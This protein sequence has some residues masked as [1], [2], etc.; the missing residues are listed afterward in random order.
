M[1]KKKKKIEQ[2]LSTIIINI[3]D[4]KKKFLHKLLPTKKKIHAR[5]EGVK[6]ISCSRKIAQTP[7]PHPTS[8]KK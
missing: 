8:L 2:V 5:L 6:K 1:K 3:F 7:P 4:F